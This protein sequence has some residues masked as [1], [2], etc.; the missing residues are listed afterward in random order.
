MPVQDERMNGAV[1]AGW[2]SIYRRLTHLEVDFDSLAA[3]HH[4]RQQLRAFRHSH[5]QHFCIAQLRYQVHDIIEVRQNE[6]LQCLPFL[7]LGRTFSV[8]EV[9]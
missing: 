1:S 9:S 2:L 3:A 6:L 7:G 5:A 8:S 4:V